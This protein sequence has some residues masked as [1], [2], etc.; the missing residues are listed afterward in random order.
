[1]S[2]SIGN[3][4][5]GRMERIERLLER[6]REKNDSMV[7]EKSMKRLIRE[8]N[9]LDRNKVED[10]LLSEGANAIH[11]WVEGSLRVLS[12]IDK[13][14]DIE[15]SFYTAKLQNLIDKL[16]MLIEELPPRETYYRPHLV[17]ATG[18]CEF[19][20]FQLRMKY[21]LCFEKSIFLTSLRVCLGNLRQELND[22]SYNLLGMKYL[23]ARD[24]IEPETFEMFEKSM[25]P[26]RGG[27]GGVTIRKKS[28]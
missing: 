22:S 24:F 26:G 12:L 15:L 7:K 21:D 1:M 25:K 14:E 3:S 20:L 27:S 17:Y 9:T 10:D 2:Y 8:I 5:R 28:K 23:Y 13:F 11:L 19:Y 18:T 6:C 4:S 16:Y